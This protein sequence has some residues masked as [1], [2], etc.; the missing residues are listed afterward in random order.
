[1]NLHSYIATTNVLLVFSLVFVLAAK[2][3]YYFKY[4]QGWNSLSFFWFTKIEL[5]MTPYKKLRARRKNQNK[6]T[7]VMG[8]LF[9]LLCF[10]FFFK[11]LILA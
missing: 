1:M 2:I 11:A 10:S 7:N 3:L 5:K 9:L 6:L 8:L 4:E